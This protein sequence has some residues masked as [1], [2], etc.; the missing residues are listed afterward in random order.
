[1]CLLWGRKQSY[2][3]YW[4]CELKVLKWLIQFMLCWI[5]APPRSDYLLNTTLLMSE[6]CLFALKTE[7][8]LRSL[9]KG[10][11]KFCTGNYSVLAFSYFRAIGRNFP[12]FGL[13]LTG[14]T[15]WDTVSRPDI[16]WC[17]LMDTFGRENYQ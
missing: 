6:A 7:G 8:C 15:V 5:P 10:R 9:E 13:R 2:T 16:L 14:S 1:M 3:V 4:T 17:N 12:M 11:A